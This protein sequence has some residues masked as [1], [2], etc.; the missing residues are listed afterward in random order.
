MTEAQKVYPIIEALKRSIPGP[1]SDAEIARYD[2]AQFAQLAKARRARRDEILEREMPG[3]L[4]D[5]GRRTA[6]C[7]MRPHPLST[8]LILSWASRSAAEGAEGAVTPALCVVGERGVGKTVAAAW[9]IA[10]T[11]GRYVL[12][13]ELVRLWLT[14]WGPDREK[15]ESLKR[16]RV[17]VV[18]EVGG[19]RHK[20]EDVRGMF[21]E[22]INARQGSKTRTLILGN[23]TRTQWEARLTARAISRWESIGY[24]LELSARTSMRRR[25]T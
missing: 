12:S 13:T 6:V 21:E 14:H 9:W 16:A 18:D 2:G 1:A 23:I 10:D 19:E 11:D 8:D 7:E 15:W 5:I 4:D 20:P 25:R 3:E 22:L 24:T 17:L